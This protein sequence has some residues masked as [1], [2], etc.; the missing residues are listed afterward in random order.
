MSPF[1]LQIPD[2][3]AEDIA[4]MPIEDELSQ[5]SVMPPAPESEELQGPT[6]NLSLPETNKHRSSV[7]KA[8]APKITKTSRYGKPY[9]SLPTGLT[10]AVV[11]T[12]ARSIGQKAARLDKDAVNA[13]IEASDSF[14]EQLGGDLRAVSNHAGR[15]TI[16]ESDMLA[17][18]RR[19]CLVVHYTV[20][21]LNLL[22]PMLD[23]EEYHS[24]QHHFI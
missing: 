15:K 10:R 4:S 2:F 16:D 7:R 12:L 13:V 14:F 9:P 22:I 19:Y 6:P 18:M 20:R 24:A 11:S 1:I 8:K 3:D 23:S 5:Q 17:V 21:C